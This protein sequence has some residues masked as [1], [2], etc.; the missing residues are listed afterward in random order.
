MTLQVGS[1]KGDTISF[2]GKSFMFSKLGTINDKLI[3][4]A[5]GAGAAGGTIFDR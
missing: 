3:A 1:N 4:A 2:A 5:G